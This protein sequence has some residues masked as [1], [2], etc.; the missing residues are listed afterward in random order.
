MRQSHHS[1]GGFQQFWTFLPI[2]LVLLLSLIWNFPEPVITLSP[3]LALISDF[4]LSGQ[5]FFGF[6]PHLRLF[7]FVL[8]KPIP[9]QILG[10]RY[11]STLSGSCSATLPL[12]CYPKYSTLS[13]A[14][15]SNLFPCFVSFISLNLTNRYQSCMNKDHEF[16]YLPLP[17][18]H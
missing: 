13:F 11:R 5:L 15:P 4:L 10:Q 12:P 2:C 1:L 8:D 18:F 7:L 3:F 16:C 17:N 6:K 14:L 9:D